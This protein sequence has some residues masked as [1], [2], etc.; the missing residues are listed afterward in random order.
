[1]KRYVYAPGCALMSYKPYLAE[2]LK[3]YVEVQYGKM[4]TL[5]TCC[6]NNLKLDSDVCVV[7]PCATCAERYSSNN[8][9]I[10]FLSELA[11]SSDFVFPDYGGIEMSIQDTC[12]ARRY[13]EYYGVIRDLLERMNIRLVEPEQTGSCAKCCGQVFYG[14]MDT[15]RVE[16]LMRVRASEMPRENVVVYCASCIMSMQ[17]GGKRPRYIIDLLYGEPTNLITDGADDWNGRLR[18]FREKY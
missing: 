6:F 8:N 10:F 15:A 7:T 3:R 4:D 18:R 9:S 5:L 17:V 1:M 16:D 12:S 13:P 2:W 14:K 11:E